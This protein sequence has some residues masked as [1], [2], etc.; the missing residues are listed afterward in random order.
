MLK[1]DGRI[2]DKCEE[3]ITALFH[4]KS[5]SSFPAGDHEDDDNNWIAISETTA[6]GT[7]QGKKSVFLDSTYVYPSSYGKKEQSKEQELVSK[8][9]RIFF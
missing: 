8:F 7:T 6:Q 2:N 9:V 5:M 1:V 4:W 3:N